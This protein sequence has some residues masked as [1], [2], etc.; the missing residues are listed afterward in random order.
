MGLGAG[1]RILARDACGHA[2]TSRR[3]RA[4]RLRTTQHG[5]ATGDPKSFL[6]WMERLIR[7]RR[8]WPE[9]GSG[10]WRILAPGDDAV[11]ALA[12]DWQG[13]E[14]VT[15]HNVAARQA[16]VRV[17]MPGA[18][19]ARR[20]QHILGPRSRGRGLRVDGGTLDHTLG[21]YEYHWFGRRAA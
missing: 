9:I 3:R 5:A 20:W 2:A 11:L 4:V 12:T 18:S 1:W 17:T 10:A 13:G 8:E 19:D 6:N 16:A 14:V 21:P 15:I 7:T